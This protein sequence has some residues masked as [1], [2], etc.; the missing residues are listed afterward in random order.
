VAIL[1]HYLAL[2]SGGSS[3]QRGV[4][5]FDPAAG[6]HS[7]C[8]LLLFHAGDGKSLLPIAAVPDGDDLIIPHL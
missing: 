2:A 7:L 1:D 3:G 5:V 6:R 8:R 4:V